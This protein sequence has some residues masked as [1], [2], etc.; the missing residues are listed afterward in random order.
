MAM[1]YFGD[2]GPFA[3]G[4]SW[5]RVPGTANSP[6]GRGMLVQKAQLGSGAW[7]W[8]PS[9]PRVNEFR[10]G[11]DHFTNLYDSVD[12]NVNP[13]AYGINT[14]VTNPSFWISGDLDYRI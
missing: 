13:L 9:S 6:F 3:R 10:V 8:T 7:T 1:Y 5:T 4:R 12:N 14:G 2:G 11:Y